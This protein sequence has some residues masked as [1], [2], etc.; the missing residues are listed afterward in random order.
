MEK[1]NEKELRTYIR[2]ETEVVKIGGEEVI[3]QGIAPGSK[4][5]STDF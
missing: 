2:P 1:N 5:E 4:P 3:M